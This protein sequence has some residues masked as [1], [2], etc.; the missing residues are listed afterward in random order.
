MKNNNFFKGGLATPSISASPIVAENENRLSLEEWKDADLDDSAIKRDYERSLVNV[1]D[2]KKRIANFLNRKGYYGSG[3]WY[4]VPAGV[5]GEIEMNGIEVKPQVKK[6]DTKYLKPSGVSP[7]CY[8]P[9]GRV[10]DFEGFTERYEHLITDEDWDTPLIQFVI[11]HP[12]IPGV[13]SEGGKKSLAGICLGHP[14]VVFPGVG[15][16]H[17]PGE[18]KKLKPLLEALYPEGGTPREAL[19]TF[20]ADFR[21]NW[22]VWIQLKRFSQEIGRRGHIVKI[23]VW[24][25][26]KEKEGMDDFIARGG[27]FDEV[28]RLALTI[29]EW[30][31]QFPEP[32]KKEKGASSKK[33][34]P[35][36]NGGDDP[37]PVE[38]AR[39][40]A[41]ENRNRWR[42]HNE[43]KMWR[44][45]N[46]KY[47]EAIPEEKIGDA[48]HFAAE[49]WISSDN[50]V[51]S[52][53]NP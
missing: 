6:G 53:P 17:L 40:L 44:E 30:E 45:W 28:I 15:Q 19:V 21:T 24:E 2:D 22:N 4:S 26:E 20:D 41:T 51:V 12:E 47:W 14:T 11:A 38:F 32:E 34:K 13:S 9:R 25:P 23:C 39:Q 29:A 18:P 31:K 10:R 7:A 1:T 52:S 46:S 42:F 27:N 37:T 5:D 3:V 8:F 43:Q 16:W 36:K 48:I 50:W 49:S 33:D 35:K